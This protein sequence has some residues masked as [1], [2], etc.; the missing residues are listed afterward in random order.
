MDFLSCLVAAAWWECEVE[1]EWTDSIHSLLKWHC[2]PSVAENALI[3]HLCR[4]TPRHQQ[5][6]TIPYHTFPN[7]CLLPIDIWLSI[8]LPPTMITTTYSYRAVFT[9]RTLYVLVSTVLNWIV[10]YL[11]Y[12]GIVPYSRVPYWIELNCIVLY[13]IASTET[14]PVLPTD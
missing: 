1:C 14:C 8:W 12:Y 6:G 7:G 9:Y 13:S 5:H 3:H 4:A 2:I 10:P 11:I